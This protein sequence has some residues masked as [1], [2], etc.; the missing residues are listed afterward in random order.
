M[1]DVET[2]PGVSC[3]LVTRPVDSVGLYIPGGSAADFHC[4]DAGC[5]G[6]NRRLPPDH[7]LLAAA[8]GR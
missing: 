7:P 2:Q 3:Q 5:S 6:K 1:I 4:P 8:G